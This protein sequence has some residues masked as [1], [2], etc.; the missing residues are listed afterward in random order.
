MFQIFHWNNWGD[1][2]RGAKIY[3]VDSWQCFPLDVDTDLINMDTSTAYKL[4]L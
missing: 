1:F 3:G 2:I 4:V